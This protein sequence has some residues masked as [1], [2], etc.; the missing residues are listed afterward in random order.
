MESYTPITIIGFGV[1][2]Q[3]L[4]SYILTEL[5]PNK[6][7][8]VD[9]DFIGGDLARSYSA[10][11]SNT[12]IDQT[13][14]SLTRLETAKDW[15]RAIE[16][17][18]ARGPRSALINLG[19]LSAD[20]RQVGHYLA[21]KCNT[22]YDRVSGLEW[23]ELSKRWILSY[24]KGSK[25]QTSIV[26]FCIGMIPRQEDYSIPTI[27]L[28]IALDSSQIYRLIQPGKNVLVVGSAHSATLVL[29]NLFT[30]PD[31]SITCMHRGQKPFKFARDNAYD[32]IKQESAEIA[33][34][35][36]SGQY[37]NLD[38]VCATDYKAVSKAMR[39]ADWIVQA[40]GFDP[41][42]P[43]IGVDAK[44]VQ[45]EWNAVQGTAIGLQNLH[46]FGAC[47]PS[48]SVI[49]GKIYPDISVGFFVDQL[50]A[51]WPILKIVIHE[52]N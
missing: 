7:T 14:T 19:N 32:G 1:A 28:S 34:A 43:T 23:D 39:Q 47:V 37:K 44:T 18:N 20:L 27:P 33:D 51:R 40:T 29:R 42:F 30:I 17:L 45:P 6:I 12:T 21:S 49:D 10:I 50:I 35:I 9:P 38:L 36:L 25:T 2:G 16:S 24:K 46:A 52:L 3:L 41:V 8:I 5:P 11:N 15:S 31:I 22:I 13:I 26:C 4:L 48:T